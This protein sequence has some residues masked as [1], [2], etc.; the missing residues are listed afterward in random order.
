MLLF[1]TTIFF[2]VPTLQ[3]VGQSIRASDGATF[4]PLQSSGYAMSV[5]FSERSLGVKGTPYLFD[6]WL[7]G[8]LTA[9]GS[10]GEPKVYSG[11]TFKLNLEN[12]FVFC[13]P[14]HS[15]D[16]MVVTEASILYVDVLTP[17][18]QQRYI[19][20]PNAELKPAGQLNS[21]YFLHRLYY[22]GK[23]KLL[24]STQKRF[25][26]VKNTGAYAP[27][28]PSYYQESTTLWLLKP[29][30]SLVKVSL[31]K[32]AVA[33]VFPDKQKEIEQYVNQNKLTLKKPE[34]W[35]KVLAYY[36]GL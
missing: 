11:L 36:E 21:G 30:G 4:I 13:I 18:G 12:Q 34:E 7:K 28:T 16:S 29:N 25:I 26:E 10:A 32:G 19:M 27:E 17:V 15:R 1:R 22:E 23:N 9:R 8:T 5:G 31:K 14:E 24:E 3:L 6:S 2:L 20:I 33:L 35:A